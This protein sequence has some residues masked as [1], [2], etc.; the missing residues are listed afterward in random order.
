MDSC[1]TTNTHVWVWQRACL[2]KTVLIMELTTLQKLTQAHCCCLDACCTASLSI[3]PGPLVLSLAPGPPCPHMWVTDDTG[4]LVV[5]VAGAAH[6][7]LDD[8][9]PGLRCSSA[10]HKAAHQSQARN[11]SQAIRVSD[12]RTSCRRYAAGRG[13]TCAVACLLARFTASA[14]AGAAVVWCAAPL[15]TP[16]SGYLDSRPNNRFPNTHQHPPPGVA[17]LTCTHGTPVWR[18]PPAPACRLP[19]WP[20]RWLG[21]GR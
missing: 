16:F 12:I 2:G 13:D 1:M 6:V 14:G 4:V 11:Q 17:S 5:P 15:L 20:P 3:T 21:R 19:G 7:G 8:A 9:H 10:L 18:S